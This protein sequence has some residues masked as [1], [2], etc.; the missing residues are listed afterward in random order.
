M[1]FLTRERT[2]AQQKANKAQKD[3]VG[4]YTEEATKEVSRPVASTQEDFLT[5]CKKGKLD[6]VKSRLD[7]GANPNQK[8]PVRTSVHILA[9][10]GCPT[11][12]SHDAE[13]CQSPIRLA[14]RKYSSL[15]GRVERAHG[16]RTPADRQRRRYGCMGLCGWTPIE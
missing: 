1:S 11:R 14:G 7:E 8:S 4:K 6:K 3:Y 12:P 5:L 10:L 9:P 15:S 2:R 16:S 13:P